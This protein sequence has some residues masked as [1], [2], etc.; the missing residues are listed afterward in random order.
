[1]GKAV[2]GVSFSEKIRD[3]VLT[4]WSLICF[5]DVEMEMLGRQLDDLVIIAHL[6]LTDRML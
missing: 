5:L 3:S 2:S 4:M 6:N 1:M